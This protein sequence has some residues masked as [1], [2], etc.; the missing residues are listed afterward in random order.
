MVN[1]TASSVA[2]IQD[3][4]DVDYSGS[5]DLGYWRTMTCDDPKVD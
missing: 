1:T 5:L 2:R 4:W 3:D